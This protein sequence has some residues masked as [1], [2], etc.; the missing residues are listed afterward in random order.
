MPLCIRCLTPR[1]FME[2]FLI[3]FFAIA[4]AEMGDKTHFL[5]LCLAARFRKPKPI[6]LGI[7]AATL[8]NHLIAGFVGEWASSFLS[9]HVLHYL[10]AASFFAAAIWA[11]IP[12]K[13]DEE[14]CV[15]FDNRNIFTTTLITFFLAEIGDKTQLA[16][17]A[18]AAQFHSL[19]AVVTGTTLGMIAANIPV[20]FLSNAITARVPLKLVRAASGIVFA[21]LGVYELIKVLIK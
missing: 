5:A 3:S 21:V 6:I 8:A 18:L 10:L 4:T 14:A 19:I 11:F 9:A 16:T 1:K 2:A 7:L 13:L 20:V 12:D 17:A 15:K